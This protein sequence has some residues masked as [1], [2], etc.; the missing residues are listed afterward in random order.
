MI[1]KI[2]ND[3][4]KNHVIITSPKTIH[5]DLPIEINESLKPDIEFIKN[6]SESLAEYKIKY[7]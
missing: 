5:V 7:E 2:Y 1:M 6:R 3:D 4:Y